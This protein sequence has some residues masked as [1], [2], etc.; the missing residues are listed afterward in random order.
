MV[1][2]FM[3]KTS[4]NKKLRRDIVC[5][6]EITYVICDITYYH[7]KA[8]NTMKNNFKKRTW[9]LFNCLFPVSRIE[10]LKYQFCS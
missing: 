1:S 4:N 9:K 3:Y 7:N 6:F 5:I 10:Y 2:G 8:G